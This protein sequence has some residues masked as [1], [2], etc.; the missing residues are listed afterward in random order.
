MA[1]LTTVDDI[2][3]QVRSVLDEDNQSAVEDS[4]ILYAINRGQDYASDLLAKHYEDVLLVNRLITLDPDTDLYDIPEDC[5]EERLEQ[6]DINVNG[7]FYETM[8]MSYRQISTYE[9]PNKTSAPAYY[10]VMGRQFKLIPA[11]T[12]AFQARIWYLKEPDELVKPQGQIV[13]VNAASNYIFINDVANSDLS[14]ESD[15]LESYINFVD[16]QTGIIK[17]SMQISSIADNKITFRSSPLRTSVLNKTIE[18][19]LSDLASGL[20]VEPD[21]YICLVK[22][23]CVPFLKKPLTHFLVQY[24]VN[25]MRRKLGEPADMEQRILDDFARQVEGQWA[26]RENTFR[27]K[28]RNTIWSRNYRRFFTIRSNR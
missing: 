4:D 25:E 18:G 26:G 13:T 17:G 27:V 15:N 12:G 14:T 2:I 3:A 24:G 5:F 1:A 23:N 6:V 10:C 7:Y 28:N 9:S 22:G 8:R 16:A 11:P 21:D 20:T 19:D